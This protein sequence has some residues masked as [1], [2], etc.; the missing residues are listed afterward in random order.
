MPPSAASMRATSALNCSST[1][2]IKDSI[3]T[4]C[5]LSSAGSSGSC[6]A[7]IITRARV[8]GFSMVDK[9]PLSMASLTSRRSCAS[10]TFSAA[11]SPT[12]PNVSPAADRLPKVPPAKLPTTAPEPISSPTPSNVF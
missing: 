6:S 8:A 7:F 10:S 4:T 3:S 12:L 1:S 9:S 2:S 11:Y 5:C